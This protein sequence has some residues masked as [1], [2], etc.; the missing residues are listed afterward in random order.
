MRYIP[1][2]GDTC[3]YNKVHTYAMTTRQFAVR[4]GPANKRHTAVVVYVIAT[5]RFLVSAFAHACIG[6]NMTIRSLAGHAGT[7]LHGA[8]VS[9]VQRMTGTRALRK[10]HCA[11]IFADQA[12]AGVHRAVAST[13]PF[14][15]R[16]G[17]VV[18]IE[19]TPINTD[20]TGTIW[21][22]YIYI[23]IYIYI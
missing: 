23:Y 11:A 17:T 10:I 20:Q 16:T 7:F 3:L 2:Q 21:N 14:W 12:I 13:V 4:L 6:V 22:I 8:R 1:I 5:P 9:K 18:E 19:C 15:T